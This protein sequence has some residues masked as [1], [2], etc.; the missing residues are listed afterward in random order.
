M[1]KINLGMAVATILVSVQPLFPM[2]DSQKQEIMKNGSPYAVQRGVRDNPDKMLEFMRNGGDFK[3][4]LPLINKIEVP[5]SSNQFATY[6]QWENAAIVNNG[7][8]F[9]NYKGK[10]NKNVKK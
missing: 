5:L 6:E 3:S 9:I 2:D 4:P 8:I 7:N 10:G 1:T